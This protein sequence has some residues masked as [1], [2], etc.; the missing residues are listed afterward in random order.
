MVKARNLYPLWSELVH[1]CSVTEG[2]EGGNPPSEVLCPPRPVSAGPITCASKLATHKLQT[3]E[4]RCCT[5][6]CVFQ[7]AR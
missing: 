1:S 7:D 2:S 6:L 4:I 3:S 5:L